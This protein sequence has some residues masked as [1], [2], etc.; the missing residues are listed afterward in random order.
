LT[1]SICPFTVRMSRPMAPMFSSSS[2]R[3]VR[4]W[5]RR[6][7]LT[8][9]CATTEEADSSWAQRSS[10]LLVSC[11]WRL[12]RSST[13]LRMCVVSES[14][15]ALA[16]RPSA[17]ARKR[18]RPR[19]SSSASRSRA[20]IRAKRYCGLRAASPRASCEATLSSIRWS[21]WL[22]SRALSW[23]SASLADTSSS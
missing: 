6:P 16:T 17:K 13:S 20:C 22:S 19:W 23:N 7:P 14:G 5:F 10:S 9:Y 3:E 11:W 18:S 2:S 21:E 8:L 1:S 12:V 4:S 15:E